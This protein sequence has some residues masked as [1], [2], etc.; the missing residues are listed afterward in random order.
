M[1]PQIPIAWMVCLGAILTAV[2][3]PGSE[4][5]I[6]FSPNGGAAAAVARHVADAQKTV[7]CA[8]YA[9]SETQITSAL[10]GAHRRG[11]T[12]RLIVDAHEQGGTSSTARKIRDAGI[13]TRVDRTHSLMHNKTIIIDNEIVVTGSMNFTLSG[14]KKNAESTLII[15]DAAIAQQFAENFQTH[16]D[17]A[18]GFADRS[19][20]GGRAKRTTEFTSPPPPL[21]TQKGSP[22][23]P[24]SPAPSTPTPP[25]GSSPVP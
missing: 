1:K 18:T 21:P 22:P 6:F 3:A 23:W 7:D 14:D 13:P 4:V 19:A 5:A 2:V 10:I 20:G 16:L 12:V 8:A 9:I 15:H 17:H 11:L 24:E 25:P